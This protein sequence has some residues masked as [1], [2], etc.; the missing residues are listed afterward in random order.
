MRST[1]W[2]CVDQ[3]NIPNISRWPMK[4]F[5]EQMVSS[6]V[7]LGLHEWCIFT[8]AKTTQ[9]R[10]FSRQPGRHTVNQAQTQPPTR[11]VFIF[12][13]QL[14]GQVTPCRSI[15]SRELFSGFSSGPPN[16]LCCSQMTTRI[17]CDWVLMRSF[18]SVSKVWPRLVSHE[19]FAGI[20]SGPTPSL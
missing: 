14:L 13:M 3:W 19:S 1:V 7:Y 10:F 4:G 12:W 15:V 9:S 6:T 17:F 20:S 18:Q 11:D 2:A 16:M 5:L 8:S